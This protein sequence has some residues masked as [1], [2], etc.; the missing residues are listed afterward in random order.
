MSTESTTEETSESTTEETTESTTEETTESTTEGTTETTEEMTVS[1]TVT[2][3][4]AFLLEEG[5]TALAARNKTYYVALYLDE[6][7]EEQVG[8]IQPIHFVNAS[9]SSVSFTGLEPNRTYYVAEVNAD[10]T[11]F[12]D[13]YCYPIYA[14]ED[15]EYLMVEFHEDEDEASTEFTNM[16]SEIPPDDDNFYFE[17]SLDIYK[18]VVDENGDPV[19]SDGVF[20]A[21][22]FTDPEF[23]QLASSDLLGGA[24]PVAELAMNGEAEAVAHYKVALTGDDPAEASLTLY[25]TETDAEGQVLEQ[26][27]HMGDQTFTFTVDEEGEVTMTTGKEPSTVTITNVVG[28]TEEGRS[29]TV[30]KSLKYY[31]DLEMF[32]AALGL[33]FFAKD[34]T[35][36]VALFEDE[37]LKD[38]VDG[39]VKELRYQNSSSSS[40]TYDNLPM[41]RT[42]YL[43]EVDESGKP[44]SADHCIP[45]FYDS[46]T[47]DQFEVELGGEKKDVTFAN[48]YDEIPDDYYFEGELTVTKKVHTAAGVEARSNGTFYAGIFMDPEFTTLASTDLVSQNI[49][50]LAMGGGTEASQTIK[51]HLTGET[52]EEARETFY[53]AETDANGRP[54]NAS[55]F[56]QGGV[57]YVATVS[58]TSTTVEASGH[59]TVTITNTVGSATPT[60]TPG[61]AGGSRTS[62]SGSGSST[63]TTHTETTQTRGTVA[64][65]DETP[66]GLYV[67]V[68]AAAALAILILVT[69]RRKKEDEE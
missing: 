55:G 56:T 2:K 33:E 68:L 31:E 58:T 7:L 48:V 36:Y 39:S 15:D 60:P 67:S 66:I 20:Y 65:G 4:L 45:F 22:I 26:G 43:A 6:D 44:Y 8:D 49:V 11:P 24:E 38:I 62:S 34:A 21:G 13:D 10:G 64:T 41:G 42:Y 40:V 35:Y 46:E 69:R 52:P 3:R 23:T 57:T 17:G 12:E 30:T 61:G 51:V 32:E 16:F 29:L 27:F 50:T 25:V 28:T 9:A 63:T 14:A 54:V 59:Q 5:D 47:P 37:D 1:L 18:K 19:T 53:I